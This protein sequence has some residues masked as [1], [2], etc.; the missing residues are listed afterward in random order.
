[1]SLQVRCRALYS[2][3]DD[4]RFVRLRVVLLNPHARPLLHERLGPG[5]L[6]HLRQ[7]AI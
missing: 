6:P 7:R 1:M 5:E 4:L 2:R 3:V